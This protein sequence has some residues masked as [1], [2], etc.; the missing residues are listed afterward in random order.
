MKRWLMVVGLLAFAGTARATSWPGFCLPSAAETDSAT[1]YA[2]VQ[3]EWPAWNVAFRDS[4]FR[5]RIKR[6]G[7]DTGTQFG[8][9]VQTYGTEV[10][11]EY[12]KKQPWNR[13][14]TLFAMQNGGAGALPY[15][16]G[17]VM[18]DSLWNYT[19]L[20]KSLPRTIRDWVW[21][22]NPLYPRYIIALGYKKTSY[23]STNC[24]GT[25]CDS[26]QVDSVY[27]INLTTNKVVR[28]W[29]IKDK[30][31]H[32]INSSTDY[33]GGGD[34]EGNV[35][36]TGRYLLLS[37]KQKLVVLDMDPTSAPWT[38]GT[39]HIT[40]TPY[41]LPNPQCGNGDG[42]YNFDWASI[43]PTG[44]YAV[45]FYDDPERA[46]VFAVDSVSLNLSTVTMVTGSARCSAD[47]LGNDV[48]GAMC[49]DTTRTDG[50]IHRLA[51]A[52]MTANPFDGNEDYIVG[53]N[54]CGS[55][56]SAQGYLLGVRLRDGLTR[57]MSRRFK[58][59][60]AWPSHVSTRALD[61]P[62]WATVSYSH[63]TDGTKFQGE[64]IQVALNELGN[65]RRVAQSHSDYTLPNPED[66]SPG[67]YRAQ[68]HACPSWDGRRV[69]YASNWRFAGTGV[70]P[71][72]SKAMVADM[73]IVPA[74]PITDLNFD[75]IRSTNAFYYF[76]FTVP[77]GAASYQLRLNVDLDE[78]NWSSALNVTEYASE[79]LDAVVVGPVGSTQ[80]IVLDR[81]GEGLP[82]HFESDFGIKVIGMCGDASVLSNVIQSVSIST[83]SP[84]PGSSRSRQF[85]PGVP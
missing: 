11:H 23:P 55:T 17:R 71:D 83:P 47:S 7:H 34:G 14:H 63:E 73:R 10:R 57:S 43:S 59:G 31:Q 52:D 56:V 41:S 81:V 53:V 25:T 64:I 58:S 72:V 15:P 39:R 69:V 74:R 9:P 8:S 36:V 32:D 62:G 84:Q 18:L 26:T 79:S 21:H 54:R 66:G 29:L 37:N 65:V 33:L 44:K 42:F 51:H 16:N 28:S 6:V 70:D 68:P 85:E 80:Q 61:D 5:T 46:R 77:A 45:V 24:G 4:T 12:S 60:E 27:W 1:I 19:G 48:G 76:N 82:L 67:W 2:P 13:D 30:I 50:W 22:P 78:S 38:P 75:P 20:A 40:T 35:S 3:E 49:G